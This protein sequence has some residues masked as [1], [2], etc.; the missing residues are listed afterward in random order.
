VYLL[1][2]TPEERSALPPLTVEAQVARV[3]AVD[4]AAAGG[5][6]ATDTSDSVVGSLAS[7]GGFTLQLSEVSAVDWFHWRTVEGMYGAASPS[8]A[9]AAAAAAVATAENRGLGDSAAPATA[10]TAPKQHPLPDRL[11]VPCSDWASYRRLFDAVRERCERAA[12]A[13]AAAAAHSEALARA[14]G[15]PADS[16]PLSSR[17]V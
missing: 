14:A 8:A 6:G 5:A 3:A 12:A 7:C 13:A 4:G 2:L 9:A 1:E 10:A 15:A 16:G 17:L 11:I